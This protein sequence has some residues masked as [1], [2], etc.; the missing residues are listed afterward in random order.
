MNPS[1]PP[2]A[3]TDYDYYDWAY[4]GRFGELRYYL[5]LF[6]G[7]CLFT[8]PVFHLRYLPTVRL[9]L[10]VTAWRHKACF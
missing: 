8:Y 7:A 5:Y 10:T 3:F 1:S 9:D 4:G 6:R 2:P